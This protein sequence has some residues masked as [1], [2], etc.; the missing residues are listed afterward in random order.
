MNA[1]I[2]QSIPAP[3]L[4]ADVV[5]LIHAG[6]VLFAVL[7]QLLI[8]VGGLLGWRWV[9]GF[10]VRI[11]HLLLVVYVAV[12][13]WL[14]ELCP[15][16]VWEHELRRA[17][18]QS[19]HDRGFVEFWLGQLIYYDLPAWVFLLMYTGFAFLVALTWW[20]IPPR[21]PKRR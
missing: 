4:W 1:D 16:T 3:G 7:G 20:W 6:I 8:M 17:A 18:G 10:W 14:G 5:L 13:A 21:S 15:L 12:Q 9:R 19:P 11:C 2:Y